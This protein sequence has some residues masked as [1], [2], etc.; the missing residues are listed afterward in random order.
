MSYPTGWRCS[1]GRGISDDRGSGSD[2][3]MRERLEA[4]LSEFGRK[5]EEGRRAGLLL[6]LLRRVRAEFG[7][8]PE[9]LIG[10][11]AEFVGLPES[12]VFSVLT[13]YPWFG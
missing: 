9:E 6:P 5:A 13:F 11:I 10:P 12:Q 1:V 4:I 2:E 3:A 7:G 8:V